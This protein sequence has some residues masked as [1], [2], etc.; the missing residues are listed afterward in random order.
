M[1][2]A[3]LVDDDDPVAVGERLPVVASSRSRSPAARRRTP[4]RRARSARR[5]RR[6][7]EAPGSS[8]AASRR[9]GRVR[10][11]GRR[12]RARRGP[13]RPPRAASTPRTS[14]SREEERA[15][16][17]RRAPPLRP[18]AI[19]T[20]SR[21]RG[22]PGFLLS[23][24]RPIATG[25]NTMHASANQTI[26]RIAFTPPAKVSARTAMSNAVRRRRPSQ[27]TTI[28]IAART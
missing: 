9:S 25:T 7:R 21:R 8:T 16:D 3:R 11:R 26:P 18:A 5:T 23:S 22:S 14:S 6:G 27:T 1:R 4:R 19:A 10:R 20:L 17:E 13:P 28:A 2:P 24:L 12:A 15:R